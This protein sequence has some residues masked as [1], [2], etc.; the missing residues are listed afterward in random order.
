MAQVPEGDYRESTLEWNLKHK[1]LPP[2]DIRIQ[3][4]DANST[5]QPRNSWRNLKDVITKS[6]KELQIGPL[7][8]Y[9]KLNVGEIRILS[10]HPG[11]DE[12]PLR[13]ILF[14]RKLEDVR[15]GYEALSYTWGNPKEK[16]LHKIMIR[17]LDAELP[18][19]ASMRTVV[20][21]AIAKSVGGAPFAI[22]SSLYRALKRL[23]KLGDKPVNI[24]VD[25]I[26]IDQSDSGHSEKEHQLEMMAQIYSHAAHVCI[27][28]DDSFENAEGAFKLVRD[29]M[30]FRVF[31]TKFH[32]S[33]TKENWIQLIKIMKAAWFSRRWIIQELALSKSA[34]LHCADQ[35]VHWDDFADAVSLLLE[36]IHMLRARF[37]EVFEDVETTNAS[38]LIQFLDDLFRKSITGDV[39]TKL[40]DLET[41]VSTLLRF[42][43]TSPRDTIYSV[44]SLANDPPGEDEPWTAIHREQLES[45]WRN[46]HGI[47][48]SED[49]LQQLQRKIALKP[50]YTISTRDVFI[51]FVTRSI[52]K[53]KSLDIICRHWA[54]NVTDNEFSEKVSM[55]SWISNLYNAPFGRSDPSRGRQNGENFVAYLPHDRQK[56]YRA[57][58]SYLAE[59]FS[60]ALDPLLQ[61]AEGPSLRKNMNRNRAHSLRTQFPFSSSRPITVLSPVENR[62]CK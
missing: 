18:Q 11:K 22:K 52:C 12:D 19:A 45:N 43:A 6:R 21:T 3:P 40:L 34:S 49:E 57:C 16:P 55:P 26:C 27:W 60:M 33:E 5:F 10:L 56:R 28:L 53:S 1:R 50:N 44:L 13:A 25:A 7:F 61:S 14:K 48:L 54:P 39:L 47:S 2:P 17:D 15:D 24:W 9:S 32:S 30:N 62:A 8:R 35:A 59:D 51:A 58:G 4:Q 41:L 46:D 38:I 31:D 23:R 42:Q 37:D 36:K 20:H 29:I